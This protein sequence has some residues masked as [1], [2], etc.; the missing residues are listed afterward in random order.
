MAPVG[1]DY[2]VKVAWGG[3]NRVE[4]RGAMLAVFPYARVLK[5]MLRC[6]KTA[7]CSCRTVGSPG[8]QHIPSAPP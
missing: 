7:F 8:E 1:F 3:R 6:V 5:A 2:H 4:D